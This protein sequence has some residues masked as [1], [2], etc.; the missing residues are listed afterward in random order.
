MTSDEV[1]DDLRGTGGTVL[2]TSLDHGKEAELREALQ[3]HVNAAES[4][5]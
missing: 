2:R 1:L 3:E 5:T 4:G